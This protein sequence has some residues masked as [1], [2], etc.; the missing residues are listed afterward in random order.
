MSGADEEKHMREFFCYLRHL[1]T[2]RLVDIRYPLD[3]DLFKCVCIW[4]YMDA[5][6]NWDMLDAPSATSN[7]FDRSKYHLEKY[8]LSIIAHLK[9]EFLESKEDVDDDTL[10]DP[11]EDVASL[12]EY[13]E[14]VVNSEEQP[15]FMMPVLMSYS[16]FA[17]SSN[18]D[19]D[20]ALEA[21]NSN[22]FKQLTKE[23]FEN[24]PMNY[25]VFLTELKGSNC[26]VLKR[27]K[28]N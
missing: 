14:T 16:Q 6:S 4:D 3:V 25:D 8:V 27:N 1:L 20:S 19:Q 17:A 2:N 11:S 15:S 18:E 22:L 28:N 9:K 23:A 21:T 24:R 12:I 13:C 7:L 10:T 5:P 26:F